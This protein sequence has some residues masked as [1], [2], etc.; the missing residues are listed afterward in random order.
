MSLFNLA[1][2]CVADRGETKWGA[3]KLGL[4]PYLIKPEA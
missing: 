2:A 4:L 3:R 1:Q